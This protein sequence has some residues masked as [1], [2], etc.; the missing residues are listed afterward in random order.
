MTDELS[1]NTLKVYKAMKELGLT[2]EAKMGTM[3]R[4]TQTCKLPKGMVQGALQDLQNKGFATRKVR[5]KAAGYYL[6]K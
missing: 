5:E 1:G 4:I 6:L 3:E 2:N